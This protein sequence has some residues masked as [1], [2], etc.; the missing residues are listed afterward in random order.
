MEGRLNER[1]L[2]SAMTQVL[3][4]HDALRMTFNA[5]GEQIRIAEPREA[6]YPVTDFSALSATEA[7]AAYAALVE[8]DARSVFRS[9]SWPRGSYASGQAGG[10]RPRVHVH[11]TP[12]RVRRLVDQCRGDRAG[13]NLRDAAPGRDAVFARRNAIHDVRARPSAARCRID[14]LDRKF[15]GEGV[16]RTRS[17]PLELPTDRPRPEIKTFRGASHCRRLN[18]KLH[19]SVKKAG[20]RHRSTLFVTLLSAFQ[21]LMGRLANQMEVVVGVPTAGQSL[22]QDQILVGH[23]VNFL[24]IRGA[25]NR[26][27]PISE[28]LAMMAKRVLDA[29]EHQ[30]YTFGTLVRKL[31]LPREPGRLPLAEIQFNLERLADRIQL[32]ELD[33]EVTPNAKARVN[34]D[35]FLNVIESADGLRIDCDYNTDL[36]DEATI[37]HWL[38]CYQALLEAFV[39][40]AAQPL[41]HASCMPETERRRLLTE[42]NHTAAEYPRD[43]CVHQLI[44]AQALA[45][46]TAVACEFGDET[47]T[48]QALNRRSNQLAHVLR[49]RIKGAKA[50]RLIGVCV[51]RSL[52]MLV[53]LVAVLK[54]GCA[55]IPLDPA[56]PAARLRAIL[57]EAEVAVLVGDASVNSPL[58][59]ADV[60]IIDMQRDAADIAAA[61]V[62]APVAAANADDL[63]YVIYTSGSTGQPKGVEITHRAVVNLL[64]SMARVPGLQKTDVLYAVTTIA[65]D[66]AGLELFLPLIVGAKVVIADRDS[67]IDGYRALHRLETVGASVMQATPAGWRM[68]L[69]AGFKAKPGFKMLC[70]GGS[71]ASGTCQSAAGGIRR[72]LEYVRTHRDHHLV[73]MHTR[74]GGLRRGNGG[75]P[76]CEYSVL[77]LR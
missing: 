28:Y 56:H 27:T 64:T 44:E 39:A 69:E 31:A 70:G 37:D 14:G 65:F 13:G 11:G 76:D 26:T 54:A 10:G 50:G 36:F 67:I 49:S 53:A 4:R 63:A 23:C 8:A 30:D 29:Y 35:L 5:T 21:A 18:A 61:S 32:A 58:V 59:G 52:D 3:A 60:A 74:V 25:W 66:I 6:D 40:D 68:L 51:E 42:F 77:R 24:P 73:F 7:E 55:Y 75:A 48:Y 41:S 38:D 33:I 20:A 62:A 17:G 19:Q 34:F 1:A 43:E 47:L 22:L 46:P 15:L 9:G 12:Y 45:T 71:V 72:T 2:R 57:A 16:C